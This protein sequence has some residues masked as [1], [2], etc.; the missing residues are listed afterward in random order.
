MNMN[1]LAEEKKMLTGLLG[2]SFYWT[3]EHEDKVTNEQDFVR[4]GSFRRIS[5][6][7]IE[8]LKIKVFQ[9]REKKHFLTSDMA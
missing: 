5:K 4:L 3:A 6:T 8:N 2:T 9:G 1:M 7:F